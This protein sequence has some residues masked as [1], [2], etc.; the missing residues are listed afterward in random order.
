[1]IFGSVLLIDRK[2][3]ISCFRMFKPK[4]I[5]KDM[6]DTKVINKFPLYDLVVFRGKNKC[7]VLK[8]RY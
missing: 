1:M 4:E 7:K 8:S 6:V 3:L 5:T 2:D